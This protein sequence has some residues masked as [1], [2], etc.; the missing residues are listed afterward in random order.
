MNAEK[1]K[2]FRI[3]DTIHLTVR[4]ISKE[5]YESTNKDLQSDD[6]LVDCENELTLLLD[7]IAIQ[8]PD[9]SRALQLMNQKLMQLNEAL[10]APPQQENLTEV[11]L[12]ACGV[13]FESD[14][15]IAEAERVELVLGLKPSNLKMTARGIV[16]GCEELAEPKGG[17]RYFIRV[18]LGG[19]AP[20]S[21]EVLIQHIIKRQGEILRQKRIEAERR[22]H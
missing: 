2:Y 16:V 6:S 18:A 1:R 9:I 22:S 12:S 15:F 5:E 20:K 13:G 17:N 14:D 8:Q 19:L 10:I 3:T 4:V 7:K 21:E 11:S